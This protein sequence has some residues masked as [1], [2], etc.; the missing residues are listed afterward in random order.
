MFFNVFIKKY[1]LDITKFVSKNI[2]EQIQWA[3]DIQQDWIFNL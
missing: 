2:I 1:N 3:K